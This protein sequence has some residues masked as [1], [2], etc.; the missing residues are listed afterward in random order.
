M[1]FFYVLYHE[2]SSDDYVHIPGDSE[3]P[4][5]LAWEADDAANANG[6]AAIQTGKNGKFIAFRM[7]S[8]ATPVITNTLTQLTADSAVLTTSEL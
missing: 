6:R 8:A 7:D 4:Y 3:A 5:R 1:P 2:E